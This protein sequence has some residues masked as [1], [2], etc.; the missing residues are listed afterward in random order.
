MVI[1]ISLIVVAL[2]LHKKRYSAIPASQTFVASTASVTF[3]A[4]HSQGNAHTISPIQPNGG[5]QDA[6]S[7]HA[8]TAASVDLNLSASPPASLIDNHKVIQHYDSGGVS[9]GNI[10][11]DMPLVVSV[12][13][14]DDV[15][16]ECKARYANGTLIQPCCDSVLQWFVVLE[17]TEVVFV[18][19]CGRVVSFKYKTVEFNQDN[20][21]LTI[22]DI[23]LADDAVVKCTVL[24]LF[25]SYSNMTHL[26]VKK[27]NFGVQTD[28]KLTP[29]EGES[30]TLPCSVIDS[31]TTD[32]RNFTFEWSLN[33]TI[34]QSC[35]PSSEVFHSD[36]REK[37]ALHHGKTSCNLTILNLSLKDE[38]RYQCDVHDSFYNQSNYN[39]TTIGFGDQPASITTLPATTDLNEGQTTGISSLTL[40]TG[41]GSGATPL[42]TISRK[43][44]VL[45]TAVS[46]G[47]VLVAI[48]LLVVASRLRKDRKDLLCLLI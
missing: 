15:E 40:K 43:D 17:N 3:R 31:G 1:V 46:S 35:N 5:E 30:A 32:K 12:F 45:I 13:E 29:V 48:S 16:L 7:F 19:G 24:G 28:G 22:L 37:Y 41:Q 23:G 42:D 33:D 47:L 27:A 20:G 9:F 36:Q 10:T 25:A 11:I 21:N 44:I 4:G 34:L 18:A 26:K 14:G 6:R 2:R 8:D 38:G 39:S